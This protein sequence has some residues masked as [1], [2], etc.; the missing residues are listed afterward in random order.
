MKAAVL[1]SPIKHSLSPLLHNYAYEL[2]G[3]EGEYVAIEM[4]PERLS[5]FLTSLDSNWRGLSLTMPLKESV[6]NL[7]IECDEKVIRTHSANTILFGSHRELSATSTDYTAFERLLEVNGDSNVAILGA[8]GTARSA[9]GALNGLVPTIDLYLRD[10]AKGL[11][12][13]AA[14]PQSHVEL[15]KLDTFSSEEFSRYDWIISTLPAGVSDGLAESLSSS[16]AKLSNLNFL[17]VLYHPWP[18]ELLLATKA[19][20]ARTLD[21]ADLLVEQ[22]LD[23]I[24]L[25]TGESFDYQT[26]RKALLAKALEALNS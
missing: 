17:E 8:G 22:A 25:M 14:A 10:F 12:P 11:A 23:Q 13:K 4:V 19:H 1:G 6:L 26:M 5:E 16:S 2:L 18:T 21:G 15:H 9:I 3:I 7:G 20:G 24:S